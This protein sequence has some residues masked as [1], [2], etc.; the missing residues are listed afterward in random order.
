MNAKTKERL[1]KASSAPDAEKQL[2]HLVEEL[3]GEGWSQLEVYDA[4][5][6][7]MLFLR[8]AR[9]ETEEDIVLEVLDFIWDG[10]SLSARLF[11]QPLT[12]EKVRQYKASKQSKDKK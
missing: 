11:P 3:K 2:I 4:F 10:C 9:R 12:N 6:T 8:N 1:D 5:E 7:Y